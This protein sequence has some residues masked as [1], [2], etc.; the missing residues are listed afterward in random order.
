MAR[1]AGAAFLCACL[2]LARQSLGVQGGAVVDAEAAVRSLRTSLSL[3]SPAFLALSG[4]G[5]A[6][7]ALLQAGASKA[8]AADP[9]DVSQCLWVPQ[10]EEKCILNPLVGLDI[11]SQAPDSSIK[12]LMFAL[13]ECG[14]SET[15]DACDTTASECT[16]DEAQGICQAAADISAPRE[17][18]DCLGSEAAVFLDMDGKMEDCQSKYDLPATCDISKE[19]SWDSRSTLC[20]FNLWK[21]LTGVPSESDPL[22]VPKGANKIAFDR[23]ELL[24]NALKKAKVKTAQDFLDFDSPPFSCPPGFDLVVCRAAEV[25]EDLVLADVY[26][27]LAH[28]E[29]KCDEAFCA[30]SDGGC[31]P[32]VDVKLRVTDELQEIYLNAIANPGAAR[33][34]RKMIFC[35]QQF[36]QEDCEEGSCLWDTNLG[37]CS[38][39]SET[40]LQ[41]L[42]AT[43]RKSREVGCQVVQGILSTGCPLYENEGECTKDG[44]G[45]CLWDDEE[46]CEPGPVGYMDIVF[47]NDRDLEVQITEASYVCSQK[48]N[49]KDCNSA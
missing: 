21:F 32:S 10:A 46:G 35:D 15:R 17:I 12:S 24:A 3:S 8:E 4:Q 42:L 11:L 47:A 31:D 29:G 43:P 38:L 41:E 14:L 23:R 20:N 34:M 30:P 36:E 27:D 40:L 6:R 19:C 26:C 13:V 33:I 22:P 44:E 2:L 48:T 28:A 25:V 9:L 37:Q 45:K 16:W 1:A 5:G 18:G 49:E 7:R 39:D